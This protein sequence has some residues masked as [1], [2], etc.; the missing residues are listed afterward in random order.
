MFSKVT[1]LGPNKSPVYSLLTKSTGGAEVGWN[2]E[3]FLVGRDGLVLERFESNVAPTSPS[4]TGAI[5]K[6]LGQ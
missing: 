3:K 4:F 6:A 1:V 5:E 2:F